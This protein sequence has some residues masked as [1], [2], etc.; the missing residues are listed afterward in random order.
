MPACGGACYTEQVQVLLATTNRGKIA[1]LEPLLADKG[2]EV[3]GLG[4]FAAEE[5]IETGSTFAENALLKARYYHHRTGMITIADDSGL[6]VEALGGE[7]GVRSARYGGPGASDHDRIIKLL[8]EIEDVPA[9]GRGARFVCAAAIVWD[10]GERVFRA[11]ARGRL[12]AELRGEGG[13]GYDPVFY[14]EPLGKTFA[15][16]T[17]EEKAEVS[18]RGAAFRSLAGWLKQSGLLD[19]VSSGDKIKNPTGDPAV[20]S[21]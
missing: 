17:R 15:E 16:L 12:L 7:P 19:T 21:V 4:D 18:H 10:G 5:D 1:E 9:T 14:Y 6:E 13:F 8:R 2:I 20:S 3:V 11:E